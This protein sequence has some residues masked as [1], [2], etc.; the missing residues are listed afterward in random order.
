MGKWKAVRTNP[1]QKIQLYDLNK[2]IGEQNDVADANP[3]I[4]AKMAEIMRTGRTE[5]DVFPMP[6]PKPSAT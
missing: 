4:T 2:D 1:N 6:K 5:S 3:K